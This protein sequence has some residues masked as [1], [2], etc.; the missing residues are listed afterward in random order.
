MKGALTLTCLLRVSTDQTHFRIT[1]YARFCSSF[2]LNIIYLF[3]KLS[4]SQCLNLIQ[5]LVF[6]R[7]SQNI[8]TH[9]KQT[10]LTLN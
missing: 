6:L 10:C 1:K 5:G 8:K 4:K 2:E 3:F 7:I 9:L